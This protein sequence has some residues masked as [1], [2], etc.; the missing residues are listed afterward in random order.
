MLNIPTLN[1]IQIGV[2]G[3]YATNTPAD[4]KEMVRCVVLYHNGDLST[5]K[6]FTIPAP[7]VRVWP[8][9]EYCINEE[10]MG[11]VKSD[12]YEHITLHVG[13]QS[14]VANDRL[15]TIKVGKCGDT[16]ELD[17]EPLPGGKEYV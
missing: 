6:S 15:V 1:W 13:V 5:Y 16:W 10:S 12:D 7:F 14:F 2:N 9:G 4:I 3:V 17:N 11:Y 8:D